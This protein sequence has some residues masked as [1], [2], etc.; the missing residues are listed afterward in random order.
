MAGKDHERD[1]TAENSTAADGEFEE[2]IREHQKMIHALCYRMTGSMSDAEDLAQETFVSAFQHLQDYRGG[3]KLSSWLYRIAVNHCI[4]WNHRKTRRERLHQT[5]AEQGREDQSSDLAQQEKVQSA[6]LKLKPKQ[7]S[8]IILTVF[9]G[10]SHAE[11]AR[12]CGC[13]E[14]TISWRIFAARRK[15]KNLLKTARP[16]IAP[17]DG[18]PSIKSDRLESYEQ[19]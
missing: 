17:T 16:A 14:T 3:S 13:S 4:N 5:W 2:I 7:R 12:V 9:E 11:A 15:L 18:P 6:L 1:R 10:L 19:R 8:A